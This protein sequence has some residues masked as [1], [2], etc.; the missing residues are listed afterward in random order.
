MIDTTQHQQERLLASLRTGL[1]IDGDWTSAQ[2]GETLLVE[3]PATEAKLVAVADAG[4]P[5]AL[6]ALDAA[7]AAQQAWAAAAPRTR[8]DILWRCYRSM[9]ERGEELA[10]LI[11]LE[12]GKPLWQ[13]RAEVTYASEFV[14]WFAEEAHRVEGRYSISPD[15]SSRILSLKQPVGPC[16]LVTPWNF[17][18]AMGTRKIA[19]AL[20]AGCTSVVKPAKQ[21]PL[22][23]LALAELLAS[24]GLPDGVVNVIATSQSP[25]LV[26]T[27]LADSRLRKISFT[28]S[29]EVGRLLL[30]QAASRVLRS[31]M[32]LGGNAPFIVFDDADVDQAV[33]QAMIAKLR[34]MGE[35][36]TA[37]NRFYAH[38]LIATRFVSALAARFA[39]LRI[40]RGTDDEV[41]VGPLIDRRACD[42]VSALVADAKQRGAQVVTPTAGR[43]LPRRGYFFPPTLLD[44]VPSHA[45]LSSEEIFG[46]VAAV[47]EFEDEE[48]VVHRA[49]ATEH[50]LVAFLF[51][52]DLSRALRIADRLEAGMV[53]INRGLVSNAAAPFGGIKQSG[54]GREGSH[55][56]IDEYLA[57]KYLA[58]DT[59]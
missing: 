50:G 11:T 27:L 59:T 17:P 18:L 15:G 34:N 33:E 23:M 52:R 30:Q 21:T 28:G 9:L 7:A 46:P 26:R 19:A 2:S 8:A 25:L 35:S 45:R 44:H 10:Y 43:E 42:S 36:C 32:E 41:D 29:T 54:L 4:V 13:A 53:G 40:G 49:N 3:D 16:L 39:K 24:A 6:Q 47:Q 31:S 38:H 58:L 5:D 55:E 37:A 22:S 12:M 14:R 1:F 56:G 20:A 57:L 48:E 51:T